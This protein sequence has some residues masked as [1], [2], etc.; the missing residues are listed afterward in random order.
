MSVNNY[1][2]PCV[3]DRVV[4]GDTI[5]VVIDVGFR[6]FIKQPIR[7]YG[8]NA[9]ENSTPAGKEATAYVTSLL[10][11]GTSVAC[12]THSPQA[13]AGYEKYG[14]WLAEVTLPDGTDL[15]DLMVATGH[16]VPYHP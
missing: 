7:L 11:A 3:V 13:N 16:A 2:F 8:I 12:H 15:A 10:P 1:T 5:V 4:D 9:P 6:I 14:R